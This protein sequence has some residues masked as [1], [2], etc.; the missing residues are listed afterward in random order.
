MGTPEWLRV[1]RGWPAYMVIFY[2]TPRR[3]TLNRPFI[4]LLP[5]AGD[6][7]YRHERRALFQD[8]A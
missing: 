4:W 7:A 5:Y 2:L 3:L 6:W 1:L 8:G